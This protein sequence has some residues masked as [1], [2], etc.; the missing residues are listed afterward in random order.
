[1]MNSIT[2]MQVPREYWMEAIPELQYLPGWLYA[3]PTQLREFGK[4]VRKFWWALDS[5]GALSEKQNFSKTLI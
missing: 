4:V 3:L 5:E 2:M 1:M